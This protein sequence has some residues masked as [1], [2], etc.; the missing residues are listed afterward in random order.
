MTETHTLIIDIMSACTGEKIESIIVDKNHRTI[1]EWFNNFIR[2]KYNDK[3][4]ESDIK[5][6]YNLLQ[7]YSY[8]DQEIGDK[9]I[10]EIGDKSIEKIDLILLFLA[11][12]SIPVVFGYKEYLLD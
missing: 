7:I 6:I 2:E 10:E 8:Y 11:N 3:L 4:Y 12:I 5:I 9:S 1:N